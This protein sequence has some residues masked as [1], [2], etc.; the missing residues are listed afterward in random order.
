MSRKQR[1]EDVQ[2]YLTP[3]HEI[4]GKLSTLKS[5]PPSFI[6]KLEAPPPPPPLPVHPLE[7]HDPDGNDVYTRLAGHY[8]E[9]SQQK[10]H[11]MVSS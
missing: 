3:V 7:D 10:R 4:L 8:T 2:K 9:S 1:L 5:N 11:K 6:E